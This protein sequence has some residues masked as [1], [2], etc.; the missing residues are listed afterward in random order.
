MG[1]INAYRFVHG[2]RERL[3]A[4]SGDRVRLVHAAA[5]GKPYSLQ[6]LQ[7]YLAACQL[8]Q[9]DTDDD[10]DAAGQASDL[11]E[12]CM[13]SHE[14]LARAS[15]LV[16][17]KQTAREL[18]QAEMRAEERNT[19]AECLS[20]FVGLGNLLPHLPVEEL[21][22]IV[23]GYVDILGPEVDQDDVAFQSKCPSVARS[24]QLLLPRNDSLNPVC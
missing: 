7:K 5:E 3:F 13:L 11:L 2:W 12:D 1:R 20:S 16:A 22:A 19:Q 24:L 14:F 10:D 23:L 17:A 8:L 15:L 21:A 6:S 4:D 18:L 9:T